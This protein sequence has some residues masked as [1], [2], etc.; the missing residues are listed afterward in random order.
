MADAGNRLT[1]KE[2]QDLK[3]KLE[4]IY[5][6]A[7][8]DLRR[9]LKTFVAV[10]AVQSMKK[11]KDLKNGKI[12]PQQYASW[13]MGQIFQGRMWNDKLNLIVRTIMSFNKRGLKEIYKKILNVFGIGYN[14]QH[15][16]L[17]HDLGVDSGFDVYNPETV[18][19]IIKEDPKILP[20]WRI[21]EEKDYVWN[22]EKVRNIVT[23]GIIQ[24]ESIPEIADRLAKEL[25]T[26][27]K[28][29]MMMFART[30]VNGA[31][32]AGRLEAMRKQILSFNQNDPAAA[33]GTRH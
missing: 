13:L 24:G 6:Q 7:E 30:A 32:N 5:G 8:K 17:D 15:Y 20:E 14:Y 29:K 18:E 25:Q 28:N 11:L 16:A 19:K 27:N 21:D 12:T 2:L 10:H 31:H 1:D 22:A 33:K 3:K 4:K 26:T 9:K 23:Q